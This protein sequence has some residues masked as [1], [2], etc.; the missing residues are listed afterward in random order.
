M[1]APG[2]GRT[3]SAEDMGDLV[4]GIWRI[5]Q[6][7]MGRTDS[8]A[9]F[10]EFLKRIPSATNLAAA[11]N[12]SQQLEQQ[13]QLQAQAQQL[14][15][16]S[17]AA[18][19]NAPIP[20]APP[21]A[22]EAAGAPL[23]GMPRV[24]SLD[25]LK[26]YVQLANNV[27]VPPIKHETHGVPARSA[28]AAPS[29]SGGTSADVPPPAGRNGPLYPPPTGPLAVAVNGPSPSSAA[30]DRM[31]ASVLQAALPTAGGVL[32]GAFNPAAAAAA[33]AAL[34]MGSFSQPRSGGENVDRSEVRRQRRWVGQGHGVCLRGHK[35][36]HR[37]CC[38]GCQHA[39]GRQ[40]SRQS[41]RLY[42]SLQGESSYPA[43]VCLSHVSNCPAH[44]HSAAQRSAGCSTGHELASC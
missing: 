12:A 30:N 1:E 28:A 11:N 14:L 29:S 6:A 17:A 42:C 22:L 27:S 34:Q 20:S 43:A 40:A 21:L 4:S 23:P 37:V 32:P 16:S 8:E 38:S 7:G 18:L 39:G 13:Q 33:A 25:L 19:G 36:K 31:L 10:Q 9:A 44:S 41:G 24:P 2:F 3:F 35:G 26:Q 5:G 15:A